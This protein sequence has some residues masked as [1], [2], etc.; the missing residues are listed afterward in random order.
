MIY[1]ALVMLMV[2]GVCKFHQLV[3]H[4]ELHQIIVHMIL[5]FL[6]AIGIQ[7]QIQQ[8]HVSLYQVQLAQK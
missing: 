1:H 2:Q 8:Q 6:N 4:M 3:N 5:N 7:L